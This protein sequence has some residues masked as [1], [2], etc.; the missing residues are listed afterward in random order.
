[1]TTT[2]N[3]AVLNILLNSPFALGIL[4]LLS[5]IVKV[6]AD[7]RCR[8]CSVCWGIVTIERDTAAEEHESE[9]RTRTA[10]SPTVVHQPQAVTSHSTD[11][12]IS[13]TNHSQSVTATAT[14]MI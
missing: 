10:R 4:A 14:T 13:D 1:M 12:V 5:V 3:A 2:D 8:T 6:C 9:L 7:S 11:V